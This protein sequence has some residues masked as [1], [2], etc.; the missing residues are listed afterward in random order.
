MSAAR[1]LPWLVHELVEY[2]AGVFLILVPFVLFG[3]EFGGG[4]DTAAFPLFVAVGVVMVLLQ[5]LTPGKASIA[6]L[7]P[8]RVHATLDYLVAIFLILSP[9]LFGLNS[10]GEPDA[11]L[12]IP[13][14]LGAG[15]LVVTLVT[16]FPLEQPASAGSAAAASGGG[17]ESSAE[18]GAGSSTTSGSSGSTSTSGSS[19]SSSGSRSSGSS[20]SSNASGSSSGPG[21]T[22]ASE[23]DADSPSRPDQSE[24]PA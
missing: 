16:R 3:D 2:A 22:A 1:L 17:T 19:G 23:S 21:S 12:I 13:V 10:A 6:D 5:L 9:F 8:V 20:G 18:Q 7:L 14:L 11:A 15:Y 4:L 24:P